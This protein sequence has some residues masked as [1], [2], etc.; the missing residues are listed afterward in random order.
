VDP[1]TFHAAHAQCQLVFYLL[2]E[3][4]LASC[5]YIRRMKLYIRQF[6][7]CTNPIV[8]NTP[9]ASNWNLEVG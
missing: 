8:L 2:Q 9:P 4:S 7:V 5:N 3:V 6:N 1:L